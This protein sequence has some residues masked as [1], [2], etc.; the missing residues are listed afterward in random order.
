M[1]QNPIAT[2]VA[3]NVNGAQTPLKVDLNGNLLTSEATAGGESIVNTGTALAAGLVAK[4]AAAELFSATVLNADS[5]S[6]FA[7]VLNSPSI[8]AT[9]TLGLDVIADFAAVGLDTV[10]G[11]GV[12][13]FDYGSSPI[14]LGNGAT[15]VFST[16][17]PPVMT[18]VA[19]SMF[20]SARVK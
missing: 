20:G 17:A 1:P 10:T 4:P 14:S 18:T 19:G 3:V 8:P 2:T 15:I 11:S 9:G 12:A 5:V 16:T 6:G 13:R 7:F